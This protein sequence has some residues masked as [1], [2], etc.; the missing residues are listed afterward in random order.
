MQNKWKQVYFT[1]GQPDPS[2][3]RFDQTFLHHRLGQ[4]LHQLNNIS[5][6]SKITGTILG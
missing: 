2:A 5:L 6:S 3:A 1:L 4:R